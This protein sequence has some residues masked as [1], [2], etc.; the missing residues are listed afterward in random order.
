MGSWRTL[1]ENWLSN[2]HLDHEAAADDA[3][4]H[5]LTALPTIEPSEDFVQR[6]VRAAWLVRSRRQTAV[7]YAAIAASV[8]IAAAAGIVAYGFASGAS[9]WAVTTVARVAASSAVSILMAAAT[10]VEWWAAMAHTGSLVAGVVTMPQNAIGLV[11]IELAGG[12]AL[13]ALHRL[14]RAESVFRDPGPL[15]L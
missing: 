13:Y 3:F 15:C 14:L 8:L 2:E 12:A 9:G 7:G 6:A 10:S 4:S 5:V 11:A 1:T